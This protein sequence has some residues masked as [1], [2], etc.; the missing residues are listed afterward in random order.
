LSFALTNG[1]T[2]PLGSSSF[3]VYFDGTQVASFDTLDSFGA[4]YFLTTLPVLTASTLTQL[5]FVGSNDSG[6][7]YLDDV[8]VNAVAVPEPPSILILG[9]VLAILA[10]LSFTAVP[11]LRIGR[12]G[13]PKSDL[14]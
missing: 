11:G 12:S 4:G 14:T 1:S 9:G 7:W 2:D 10:G 13:L 6:D 8:S 3:T 5:L